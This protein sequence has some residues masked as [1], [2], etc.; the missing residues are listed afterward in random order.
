[1][2]QP[3]M[4]Y[5]V[6]SEVRCWPEQSGWL[7]KIKGQGNAKEKSVDG[8]LWTFLVNVTCHVGKPKARL[9]L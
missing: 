3:W 6:A 4:S 9:G 2:S 7:S 1:M 5:S 8:L